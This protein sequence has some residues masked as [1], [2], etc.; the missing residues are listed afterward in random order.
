MK[1][2]FKGIR[3]LTGPG[4]PI[5]EV[6]WVSEEYMTIMILKGEVVNMWDEDLGVTPGPST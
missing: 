3:T 5:Q 6:S 4:E 2:A 1:P